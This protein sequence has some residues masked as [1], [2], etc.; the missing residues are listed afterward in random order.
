MVPGIGRSV[1]V[2]ARTEDHCQSQ[3]QLSSACIDQVL[4][5]LLQPF[6]WRRRLVSSVLGEQ[7]QAL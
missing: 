6:L 4:S 3:R 7:L 1:L 5:Q 2:H